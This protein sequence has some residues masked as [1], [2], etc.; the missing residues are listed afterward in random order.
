MKFFRFWLFFALLS[1]V[2]STRSRAQTRVLTAAH[3]IGKSQFI[4]ITKISRLP[5]L[6]QQKRIARIYQLSDEAKDSGGRAFS[7]IIFFYAPMPE[8]AAQLSPEELAD[9]IIRFN[10]QYLAYH[11]KAEAGNVLRTNKEAAKPLILRDL[12]SKNDVEIKRGFAALNVVSSIDY[13]E[14]PRAQPD[15]N[16]PRYMKTFYK[17]VRTIF[18]RR[19]NFKDRAARAFVQIGDTRAVDEMVEANPQNPAFYGEQ[20]NSFSAR[21]APHPKLLRLLD[22]PDAKLRAQAMDALSWANPDIMFPYVERFLHDNDAKVRWE[23]FAPAAYSKAPRYAALNPVLVALMNDP[24]ETMRWVSAAHFADVKNPIAL[25]PL[26][27]L[28]QSETLMPSMRTELIRRLRDFAGSDFGY[29]DNYD[30]NTA[31]VKEKN[32]IAL[33]KFQ[34]WIEEKYPNA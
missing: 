21:V 34:Q 13:F 6:E 5:R 3:E 16:L 28:L 19:A 7:S 4:E 2:S 22:S 17:S 26:L 10:P 8:N 23:A 31:E 20:L 33:E 11:A 29:R 18:R 14:E 32:R 25:R 12:K 24:D 9:S 1:C 15:P 27:K 30:S